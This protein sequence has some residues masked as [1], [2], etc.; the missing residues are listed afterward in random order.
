[1]VIVLKKGDY[2]NKRG[3]KF[4]SGSP[5]AALVGIMTILFVFYILFLPPESR[6]ELLEGNFSDAED[7]TGGI[8]LSEAPGRLS[9]TEKSVFDH[10]IPN[11]YLTETKNAVVLA[12]ENPFVV[13]KGWF[14]EQRKSMVFSL[15]DLENTDNVFLSFQAG[16]RAGTLFIALNGRLIYESIVA[17][18]NPAPVVLPKS[19]LQDTNQLDFYVDGGF[20]SRKLYALSDVKVVGD[21]TDLNRQMA[22]NTF[23]ISHTEVDN[24]DSAFLDFFPICSQRDVGVLTIELNGKVVYSAVPACESLNR[25]DLYVEDLRPNKNTLLFRISKGSYRVEQ[26]RVRSILEPVKAYVDYFEV[27]SAL[28]NDVLDKERQVILRIEF[29]DDKKIKRAEINFNGK[30]DAIDQRDYEYERDVSSWIKEGSN[31]VEIK[32]LTELDVVKLEVRAD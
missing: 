27:K 17:I 1:M 6:Q 24:L 31:Y 28:F 20:F 13:K 22:T 12:R 16:E 11:I 10:H 25:Q 30:R 2:M 32:P 14:G 9:F 4:Q 15:T 26:I 23:S 29:I 3:E 5:A 8:L 19:L 7:Y 21:I 18:Q